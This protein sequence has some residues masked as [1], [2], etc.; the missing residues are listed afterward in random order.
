MK[1]LVEVDECELKNIEWF[2]YRKLEALSMKTVVEKLTSGW[3]I[4]GIRCR[5]CGALTFYHDE[6][7]QRCLNCD[8]VHASKEL[9]VT[10]E[11]LEEFKYEWKMKYSQSVNATFWTRLKWLLN[12]YR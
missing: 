4:C 9:K 6:K 2:R 12:G 11:S 7:G 1:L 10:R 5:D 8:F 3:G